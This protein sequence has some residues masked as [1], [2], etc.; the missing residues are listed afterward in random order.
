MNELTSL[1][2]ITVTPDAI[3]VAG[4]LDASSCDVLREAIT[5]AELVMDG[6]I[7]LDMSKVEF[8]DSAGIGV[9][10]S[11]FKS[12]AEGVTI[13]HAS[14]AVEHVLQLTGLYARFVGEPDS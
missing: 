12:R 4:E 8:M 7:V 9:L 13:V 10:I 2:D 1:V 5:A 3:H 11:S 6:P 14:H